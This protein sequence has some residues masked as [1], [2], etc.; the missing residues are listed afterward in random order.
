[1]ITCFPGCCSGRGGGGRELTVTRGTLQLVCPAPQEQGLAGTVQWRGGPALAPAP[2]EALPGEALTDPLLQVGGGRGLGGPGLALLQ[3]AALVVN[4]A[5]LEL[6]QQIKEALLVSGRGP[7][8]ALGGG[9][10]RQHQLGPA[11][12]A[13]LWSAAPH[14]PLHTSRGAA[15]PGQR[16]GPSSATCRPPYPKPAPPLASSHLCPLP[17]PPLPGTTTISLLP[18]LPPPCRP[19]SSSLDRSL[20]LP[21]PPTPCHRDPH[22]PSREHLPP[23]PPPP[24]S[25]SPPPPSRPLSGTC[26]SPLQ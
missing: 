17:L 23:A 14:R 1:M 19:P 18:R 25:V 8:D 24:S 9:G 21:R 15:R 4:A 6:A 16:S 13:V 26:V 2:L 20:P 7:R 22:L 3:G 11:K 12:L 5:A 10:G